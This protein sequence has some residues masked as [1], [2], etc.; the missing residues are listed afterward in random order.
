MEWIAVEAVAVAVDLENHARKDCHQHPHH[1]HRRH[2]QSR[3]PVLQQQFSPHLVH[4]K[5]F[6]MSHYHEFQK[7]H[8]KSKILSI[9][10]LL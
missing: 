2:H 5:V 9:L 8:E 1:H 3:F 10:F 7:L 6:L 4:R